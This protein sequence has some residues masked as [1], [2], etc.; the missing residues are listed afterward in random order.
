MKIQKILNYYVM[1][2]IFILNSVL[3][4]AVPA[5][6]IT[7]VN[8]NGTLLSENYDT[9]EEVIFKVRVTNSDTEIGLEN[10]KISVPLSTVLSA[11]DTSGVSTSAFSNLTNEFKN[12]SDDAIEGDFELSGDFL[13]T[14]VTIPPSGYI[15]YFIS[16]TVENGIKDDLAV[17][18]TVSGIVEPPEEE[19]TPEYET[20][21][22][23]SMTLTRIPYTYT[24]VKSTEQTY[25]EAEGTIT[26]KVKVENTG[27]ATIKDFILT[28]VFPAGLTVAEITAT[29]T[30][31]SSAGTFSPTGNST[32]DLEATAIVILPSG[33]VEYTIVADVVAGTT[34]A[35]ENK[36]QAKVR[37]QTADSNTVTLN[38]AAYDFTVT[39]TS[40]LVNYTPNQDLTYKVRI[41]NNSST[42]KITQ[43]ELED[44]LSEIEAIAA[45]GSSK[46]VFASGT[47]STTA[48]LSDVGNSAG[49][50][51]STGDNL[52]VTDITILPNSYIEYTIVGKVN[53][54]ISGSITNEVKVT[55][56]NGNEETA[57]VA[58]T[59]ASST[60]SLTKTADVTE[61]YKPGDTITYTV[62]V[63]NT[64]AGIAANYLV[65]DLISDVV[66]EVGN[67]GAPLAA[68]SPNA[69]L[70][71]S[72]TITASLGSGSTKSLSQ[73]IT[74]GG[75]SSNLD[76]QDTVAIFPGE[77]IVYTIAAQTSNAAIGNVTNEADLQIV[78]GGGYIII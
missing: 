1:C 66:G 42:V 18:G 2:I 50:F 70:F 62:T 33:N 5:I 52:E 38:L 11:T 29:A 46:P 20:L 28:D 16:G 45:D 3:L 48:E 73:L 43:M 14:G 23:G 39:K 72:W 74:N 32:G 13:A 54:D 67:N 76:L 27:V 60:L 78:G 56:R 6:E 59:S 36:A 55:D 75:T 63:E 51:D 12:K 64:G 26:Y 69:S 61:D 57:D 40:N 19:Q 47:M 10:L 7:K 53:D 4:L 15:E 71:Q 49:T 34:G 21:A 68:N 44:M 37:N 24:V 17:E 41:T 30:G 8:S 35:I 77:K 65:K 9:G 58:V 31:G 25:Y 22:T